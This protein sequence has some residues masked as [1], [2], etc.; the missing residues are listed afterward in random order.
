MRAK[1]TGGVVAVMIGLVVTGL[2]VGVPAPAL[3]IAHGEDVAGGRYA[4]SALLSM[5]GLPAPD[6][7]RRDSSCSGALIAATWVI[8]AGHCFRD[9]DGERVGRT[10]AER[11]TVTVG[12]A[13]VGGDGGRESEVVAVHQSQT[14][15]VALVEIDP[16][17]DDIEPLRV[18]V[19]PAGVGEVVRLTGFG[20]LDGLSG[21]PA[22]RLQTGE[23][24]VTGVGESTLSVAG[25]APRADTSACAHDSGGPYFRAGPDGH[26]ELVGVV[27]R[28]PTCPHEGDDV[29]ARTDNLT[30]WIS[31]TMDGKDGLLLGWG[32]GWWAALVVVCGSAVVLIVR[33]ATARPSEAHADHAAARAQH[34]APH[35]RGPAG[36]DRQ[37]TGRRGAAAGPRTTVAG[38]GRTAAGRRHG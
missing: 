1:T 19:T 2:A 10:V 29:S 17:I 7:G 28:G 13:E 35:D 16:P 26:A 24:T 38:R 4:F 12:R 32:W 31:D 3:A 6:H 33:L 15:D 23:F 9:G 5:T 27:S 22:D 37:Q 8:T 25:L 36:Y 21:R 18:G 30:G 11:T 14:A 34:P 20:L